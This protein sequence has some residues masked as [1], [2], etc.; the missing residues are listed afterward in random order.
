MAE[1]MDLCRAAAGADLGDVCP[2]T[3][4][5]E[6]LVEDVSLPLPSIGCNLN[7]IPNLGMCAAV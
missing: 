2:H 1:R 7:L 3:A 4:G 6:T 5:L